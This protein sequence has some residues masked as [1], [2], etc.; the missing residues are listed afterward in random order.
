MTSIDPDASLIMELMSQQIADRET[1][2]RQQA[3]LEAMSTALKATQ[4]AMNVMQGLVELVTR[5]GTG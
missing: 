3:Q 2:A 5:R 1:I 4:H